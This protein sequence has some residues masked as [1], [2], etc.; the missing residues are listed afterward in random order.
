MSS[1]GSS[2]IKCKFWQFSE[3]SNLEKTR[4]IGQFE[5]IPRT[6][7]GESSVECVFRLV[8]VA[9]D[10]AGSVLSFDLV[11]R[12]RVFTLVTLWRQNFEGHLKKIG[13]DQFLTQ[14]AKPTRTLK[15]LTLYQNVD[16]ASPM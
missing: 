11:N 6:H 16:A 3:V 1:W 10:S 7:G 13:P 14:V 4:R 2:D 9:M 15:I 12:I 5:S 8:Q